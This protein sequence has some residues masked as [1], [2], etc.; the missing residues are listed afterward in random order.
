MRNSSGDNWLSTYTGFRSLHNSC[1]LSTISLASAACSSYHY[2][3]RSS[4]LGKKAK[5]YADLGEA[6]ADARNS[7]K[8]L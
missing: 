6:G 1:F 5:V 2:A 3:A 8:E 4:H 7:R